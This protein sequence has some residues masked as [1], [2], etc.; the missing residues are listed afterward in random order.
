MIFEQVNYKN[1][2]AKNRLVRSATWEGL[3]SPEG[4]LNEE[5]YAIYD[6]LAKGGVGTIVTGLTDVSPYNWSLVG[7]MRLC[8]DSLIPDYKKLTDIVHRYNCCIWTEL[9]MN[10]YMRP[11]RGIVPVSID[12]L[13][14]ADMQ[15]VVSLYANAA[16]RAARAGFDGV[17]LHLAYNWFLNRMVNPKYNHRTDSYGGSTENRV[18]VIKDIISAIRKSDTRMHISAKFSFF[19]DGAGSFAM[20]ECIAICGELERAGVESIE[21]LGGHSHKERGTAYEACYLEL[22]QAAKEAVDL[23]VI[24]TG[25]NH[26]IDSM[27]EIHSRDGIDF[28]GLSRPLIREPHLPNKWKNGARTSA[29]CISCGMCYTTNGKRCIFA[30]QED[31]DVS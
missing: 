21:V 22:G 4:F 11:E 13:T 9:N 31:N 17:Q 18:R 30:Q 7:N 24:L 6:E 20:Q 26:S 16:I 10:Q 12:D 28:F 15:D 1:L 23:P 14:D 19:D 2:S 29:L 5:I 25:N 3:A 8:S 27:N